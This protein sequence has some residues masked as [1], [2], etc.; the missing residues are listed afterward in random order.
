M[1]RLVSA[2]GWLLRG[3]AAVAVLDIGAAFVVAALARGT[4]PARVLQAI[5]SG[6]V[7][8]VAYMGGWLT[9]VLG[10]LLHTMIATGVVLV[11]YLAARR[12]PALVA[13]PVPAGALYGVLV[14]AVMQFV[15]LP[16]SQLRM[17]QRAPAGM[18]RAIMIH[19]LFVGIPA[20]LAVRR[21]LQAARRGG[22]TTTPPSS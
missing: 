4:S 18:A 17:G 1:T 16:L 2:R 10:A 6:L 11:L 12:W 5:A 9:V 13:R 7:G 20:A 21:A 19:I 3:I 15:V 22:P 14:W 8:S